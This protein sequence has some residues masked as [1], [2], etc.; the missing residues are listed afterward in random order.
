[1]PPAAPPRPTAVLTRAA[2]FPFAI[3]LTSLL[4]ALRFVAPK[5]RENEM[6]LIET[7][8]AASLGV[9]FECTIPMSRVQRSSRS[10]PPGI[11]VTLAMNGRKLLF[12]FHVTGGR[13]WTLARR[14]QGAAL[15]QGG[16]SHWNFVPAKSFI[17]LAPLVIRNSRFRIPAA[18]AKA[19]G[20]LPPFWQATIHASIKPRPLPPPLQRHLKVESDDESDCRSAR[21]S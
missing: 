11:R 16:I 7:A 20:F 9:P 21:T 10:D 1:M 4:F 19:A 15:I 12:R 13:K 6:R 2:A 3:I 14:Q 8:L 5:E 18:R 17:R